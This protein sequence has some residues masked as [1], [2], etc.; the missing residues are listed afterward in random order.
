ITGSGRIPKNSRGK[1]MNKINRRKFIETATT[2]AA[3]AALSDRLIESANAAQK[4]WLLYIGTYTS[5]KSKSEGIY[6]YRMNAT[7]GELKRQGVAG[8]TPD[9]SFLAIDPSHRYLYAAN[10]TGNFLGKI[11]GGVT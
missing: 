8:A 7:T 4:D 3:G 11:N 10:D 5:G 9:P 6:I 2:F 1:P